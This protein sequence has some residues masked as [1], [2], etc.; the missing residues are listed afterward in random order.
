MKVELRTDAPP[1]PAYDAPCNGCGL[2]CAVETCPL[3]LVLFRRRQG[4]CPALVWQDGRYVCGV[5]DRPKDF[6]AL[7]PTAWA[8]RLVAR[9]IAAGKGCD[10]RHEAE[11][12]QDG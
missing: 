4:P 2:C 3:G 12:H 9:W 11:E 1:K 10:C 6:I 7:L 5:L 8:A